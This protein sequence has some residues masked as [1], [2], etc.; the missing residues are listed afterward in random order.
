MIDEMA[1]GAPNPFAALLPEDARRLQRR[2]SD[3]G[4]RAVSTM[5]TRL[6]ADAA[7]VELESFRVLIL[8]LAGHLF[9]PAAQP[10]APASIDTA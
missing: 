9:P 5:L 2:F 3:R 4:K 8:N 1:A 6:R 10:Q 7:A